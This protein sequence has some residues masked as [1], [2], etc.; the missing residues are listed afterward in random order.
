MHTQFHNKNSAMIL[1]NITNI[2][3]KHLIK[4]NEIGLYY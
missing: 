1:N 3:E 4:I 2:I